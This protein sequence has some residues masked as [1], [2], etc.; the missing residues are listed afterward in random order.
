[1]AVYVKRSKK[2]KGG[3]DNIECY[4]DADSFGLSNTGDL[5]LVKFKSLPPQPGV[6]QQQTVGQNIR[7]IASG[8]WEEVW[9]EENKVEGINVMA[10][11]AFGATA[12]GKPQ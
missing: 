12:G 11:G 8:K 5:V 9:I 6:N 4:H 2:V 3:E 1:M 10:P 7:S